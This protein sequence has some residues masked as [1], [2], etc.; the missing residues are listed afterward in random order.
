M[1]DVV[2]D[3]QDVLWT[4][5]FHH[6]GLDAGVGSEVGGY[7][8]GAHAACA[9]L[10]A[11]ARGG[12]DARQAL[13]QLGHEHDGPRVRVGARVVRVQAVHV[14]E[15]EQKVCAHE[16][17]GDGRERVIVAE[18]DLADGQRVVFVDNGDDAHG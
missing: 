5:A 17:G 10:G 4:I 8:L 6:N 1:L 2:D 15:Q 9:D 7:E 11:G 12:V 18:L 13:G 3:G 14:R 16:G